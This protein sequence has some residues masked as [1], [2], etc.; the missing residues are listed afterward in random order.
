RK[1]A[2][3]GFTRPEIAV[4]MAYSKNILKAEIA[5]SDLT[6]DAYLNHYI[7]YAFPEMLRQRYDKELSHHRLRKEIMATQLSNAL[8]TDMGITFIYQM[9]DET[10]ASTTDIVS[11]YAICKEIF[12]LQEIWGAVESLEVSITLQK[13]MILE[14]V[15]LVRRSVRWFL[16]N[17]P[18]KLTVEA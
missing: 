11:A 2:G 13:E 7:Q 17:L 4:L 16:R 9:Y 14:L 10:R 8:I 15:R 1:A 18:A 12:N 5:S 3:Q 6:N